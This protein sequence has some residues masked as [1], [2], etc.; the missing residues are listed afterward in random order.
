[1]ATKHNTPQNTNAFQ[2]EAYHFYF[3]QDVKSFNCKCVTMM[4]AIN[5]DQVNPQPVGPNRFNLPHENTHLSH[6]RIVC[7]TRQLY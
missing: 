5:S 2:P 6:L 4:Q 7:T 1:M 3:Q